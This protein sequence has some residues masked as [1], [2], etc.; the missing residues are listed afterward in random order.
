MVL[1]MGMGLAKSV[2]I[3]QTNKLAAVIADD[4]QTN[5]SEFPLRMQI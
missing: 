3:Q 2:Q 1:G 5:K 4:L